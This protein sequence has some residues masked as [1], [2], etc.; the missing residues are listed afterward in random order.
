[1][2][3]LTSTGPF[4]LFYSLF[5]AFWCV[6]VPPVLDCPSSNR[7]RSPSG[8]GV[9][10]I[11][12]PGTLGGSETCSAMQ[13]SAFRPYQIASILLRAPSL[14]TRRLCLWEAA[15]FLFLA[16]WL[17]SIF[18]FTDSLQCTLTVSW[19]VLPSAAKKWGT[20]EIVSHWILRNFPSSEVA[21]KYSTGLL[22]CLHTLSEIC[23]ST[24][25]CVLFYLSFILSLHSSNIYWAITMYCTILGTEK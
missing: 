2:V 17:L 24:F 8:A 11:L 1:M 22:F 18:G 5:P 9:I 15:Q 23:H 20:L 14:A 12:P 21:Y 25:L 10:P 4:A 13:L 19:T 3:I 6:D 16:L 7:S